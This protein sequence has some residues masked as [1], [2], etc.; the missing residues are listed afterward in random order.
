MTSCGQPAYAGAKMGGVDPCRVKV[1]EPSTH[2]AVDGLV[3]RHRRFPAHATQESDDLHCAPM[4]ADAGG[5]NVLGSGPGVP[6][7]RVALA[8]EARRR[9]RSRLVRCTRAKGSRDHR[10]PCRRR[11]AGPA[12]SHDRISAEG[13]HSSHQRCPTERRR[14]RFVPLTW[15]SQ[16]QRHGRPQAVTRNGSSPVNGLRNRTP[17][18]A[19][20]S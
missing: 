8:E 17:A 15:R 3:V 12:H 18:S 5:H 11:L 19:R 9:R 2:H 20:P 1:A 13:M 7:F 4:P 6:T 14:G 10:R 16:L